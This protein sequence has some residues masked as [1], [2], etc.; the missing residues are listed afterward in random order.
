MRQK[1]IVVLLEFYLRGKHKI[2]SV[3]F[4]EGEEGMG[5]PFTSHAPSDK[6]KAVW[7]AFSDAAHEFCKQMANVGDLE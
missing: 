5:I 3:S 1:R 7:K 2:P 4:V 6:E